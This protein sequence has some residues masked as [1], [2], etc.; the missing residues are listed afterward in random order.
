MC[1]YYRWQCHHCSTDNDVVVRCKTN[2][3]RQR[4]DPCMRVTTLPLPADAPKLECQHCLQHRPSGGQ[5]S[6]ERMPEQQTLDTSFRRLSLQH[7]LASPPPP[8]PQTAHS[9]GIQYPLDNDM[10]WLNPALRLPNS[11]K[12]LDEYNAS[13]S[14]VLANANRGRGEQMSTSEHDKEGAERRAS[15]VDS[16]S[17]LRETVER[18]V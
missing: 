17:Q 5:A 4:R 15:W 1:Q 2:H 16:W 10:F 6:D 3:Q 8:P 7:L 9:L 11:A 18:V 14:K 13:R 12:K